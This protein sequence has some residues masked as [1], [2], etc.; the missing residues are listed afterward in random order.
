MN[1][2]SIESHIALAQMKKQVQLEAELASLR[3]NVLSHCVKALS[4]CA[5]AF[6]WSALVPSSSEQLTSYCLL[7][8]TILIGVNMC[9]ESYRTNKRIDTLYKLL[10]RT[11]HE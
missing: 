2:E 10:K 1:K 3:P 8:G 9:Y 4:V 7:Y 5:L 11:A 6:G